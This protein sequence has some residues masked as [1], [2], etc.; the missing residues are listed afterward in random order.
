MLK[1]EARE[2]MGVTHPVE[3]TRILTFTTVEVRTRVFETR[4]WIGH[5]AAVVAKVNGK[6]REGYGQA[7]NKAAAL[8]LAFRDALLRR[9]LVSA[10]R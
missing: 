6:V 1:E 2:G 5:E 10:S 9:D 3:R 7:G 4:F 8:S